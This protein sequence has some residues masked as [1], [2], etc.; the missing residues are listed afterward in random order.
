MEKR[1]DTINAHLANDTETNA[2]I[3]YRV[4]AVI[5]QAIENG[6]LKPHDQIPSERALAEQFNI[7]RMTARQA[8]HTLLVEGFVYKKNRQGTFV[9]E[10]KIGFSVGSF[11]ETM[12]NIGR[13]P[14]AKIIKAEP[15]RADEIVASNLG[16]SI[17]DYVFLIRRLRTAEGSPV[18]IENA[19]IPVSVCPELLQYDVR[20]SLWR[21]L[22]EHFGI[23]ATFVKATVQAIHTTKEESRLL[24]VPYRSPA[25]LLTR[26]IF[27]Q[28]NR[29]MEY[30][31]DIYRGDKTEFSVSASV[32]QSVEA[33][34]LWKL[35]NR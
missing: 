14:G 30:A 27:D 6:Y 32:D 9:A 29:P 20:Q 22:K 23:V 10:P 21:I 7:S 11:S 18:S 26:I 17:N 31:R 19:F 28:Q 8:L 4:A 1:I 24:E 13:R 3:Y 33:F 34:G 16:I 25:L 15:I 5:K 2:P 12:I 35:V